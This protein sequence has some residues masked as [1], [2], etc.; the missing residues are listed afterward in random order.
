L[1]I[2]SSETEKAVFDEIIEEFASI[3]AQKV[4]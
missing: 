4:F 2:E 3:R 1:S